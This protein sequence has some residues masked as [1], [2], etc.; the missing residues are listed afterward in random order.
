M[1]CI[2]LNI[3]MTFLHNVHEEMQKME[4]RQNIHVSICGRMVE[5][6]WVANSF[7]ICQKC[8]KTVKSRNFDIAVAML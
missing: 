6:M 3:S 2:D 1:R 5:N 4:Q 7:V 8:N